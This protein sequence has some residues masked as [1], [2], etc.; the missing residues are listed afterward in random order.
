MMYCPSVIQ[1]ST[2]SPSATDVKKLVL[3][4]STCTLRGLILHSAEWAG[5]CNPTCNP[6]LERRVQRV[7]MK[8]PAC[9]DEGTD[10]GL[11]THAS[12]SMLEM[13]LLVPL[14][15]AAKALYYSGLELISCSL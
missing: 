12:R 9:P 1:L 14:T 13:K 11:A 8:C 6:S 3:G 10:S 5:N 4:S 15:E 2:G 7:Q